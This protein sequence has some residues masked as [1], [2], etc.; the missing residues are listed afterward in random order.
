MPKIGDISV[1]VP[2]GGTNHVDTPAE[3]LYE[4]QST[5]FQLLVYLL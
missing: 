4:N 5:V 1:E 2:S 3:F